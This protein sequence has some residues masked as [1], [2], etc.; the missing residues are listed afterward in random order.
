[1][2][3]DTDIMAP[4]LNENIEISLIVE[5]QV[6]EVLA[7]S[8]LQPCLVLNVLKAVSVHIEN[9]SSGDRVSGR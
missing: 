6:L 4:T 5:R 3:F 7:R 8:G 1:M 2:V 9:V